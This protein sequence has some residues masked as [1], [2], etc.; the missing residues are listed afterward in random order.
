MSPLITAPR[1]WVWITLNLKSRTCGLNFLPSLCFLAR[2]LSSHWAGE[3]NKLWSPKKSHFPLPWKG[4]ALYSNW[5]L[6]PSAGQGWGF[7]LLQAQE[8]TPRPKGGGYAQ[9]INNNLITSIKLLNE[10]SYSGNF[11]HE[12]PSYVS[13]EG[14][15]YQIQRPWVITHMWTFMRSVW[16]FMSPSVYTDKLEVEDNSSKTLGRGKEGMGYI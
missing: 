13:W 15:G 4:I 2:I 9:Q 5:V 14:S 12:C 7:K 3:E 8:L 6:P 10:V 16:T 11:L 1:S